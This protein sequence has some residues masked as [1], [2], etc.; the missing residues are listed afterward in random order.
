V[1]R[2]KP[3][4]V[5][6]VGANNGGFA[7]L[8][9]R[10]GFALARIV[11]VELNPRTCVRLRF[12]LDRNLDA[13]HEVVTAALCGRSGHL[14]VDLGAGSVGDNIYVRHDEK[15]RPTTVR[16]VTFDEIV[17]EQFGPG[18]LLDVC[19]IDIEHAEYEV[20]ASANHESVDRCRFLIVEIHRGERGSPE[21]LVRRIQ[22]R[23]FELMPRGTD[24]DVYSFRNR[25][26]NQ[27]PE[28]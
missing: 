19:K 2:S 12:N 11:C 4:T 8:L 20:F 22:G 16:A 27:I 18:E 21:D 14:N 10:M 24:P 28:D 5:L 17:E 15:A 26:L 25:R 9:K 23:G 3:L 13:P 1:P 7:L 6:D